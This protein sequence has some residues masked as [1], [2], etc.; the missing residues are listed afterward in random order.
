MHVYG[1]EGYVRRMNECSTP[2]LTPPLTYIYEVLFLEINEVQS[3]Y[4]PS[5]VYIIYLKSVIM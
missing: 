2:H 5:K 3:I 1:C 4:I